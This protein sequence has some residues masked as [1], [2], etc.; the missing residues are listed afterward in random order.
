MEVKVN[1]LDKLRLEV[2]RPNFASVPANAYSSDC[3]GMPGA[4][5]QNKVC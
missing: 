3:A 5:D 2:M 4:A 1:F